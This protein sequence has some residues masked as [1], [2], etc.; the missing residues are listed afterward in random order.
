MWRVR[1]VAFP[2]E[3]SIHP[4]L[5]EAYF[6]DAWETAL[7]DPGLA[8]A[9]IAERALASTP[10]WVEAMLRLR[11]RLVR[12]FGVRAV[13]ALGARKPKPARGWAPGD[14]LSIFRIESVDDTELVMGID[15]V[16]LD[17][18]VSFLVRRQAERP[19]WV[20]SS[21]VKTHNAVGKV[22]MWPVAPFHTWIVIGMMRRVQV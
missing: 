12:P 19:T 14:R 7:N 13:E 3:S 17:V 5:R 6:H 1:R 18:R 20:V 15:D 21:W 10:G 11:N 16:H 2:R 22:Y 8:P 9:E 4:R